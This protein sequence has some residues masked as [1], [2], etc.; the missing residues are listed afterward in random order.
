MK[1]TKREPRFIISISIPPEKKWVIDRIDV[2]ARMERCR[3]GRSGYI[4]RLLEEGVLRHW[5]GNPQ[6]TLNAGVTKTIDP[7]RVDAAICY[8][9]SVVKLPYRKIGLIVG[10][11]KSYVHKV[12]EKNGIKVKSVKAK[13]VKVN[14]YKERFKIF[15]ENP[16]I[17][18]RQAFD[19]TVPKERLIRVIVISAKEQEEIEKI[20]T[21]GVKQEPSKTSIRI[22]F[23]QKMS[24]KMSTNVHGTHYLSTVNTRGHPPSR[25]PLQ[26]K[27]V[28]ALIGGGK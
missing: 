26:E 15:M 14:E 28:N 4:L 11:S 19:F 9:R 16:G 27:G 23:G 20:L 1:T 10:M 18:P 17:S 21:G 5:P 2:L 12:C 6:T 13:D 3:G 25:S 22:T 7:K 8:L 24:T